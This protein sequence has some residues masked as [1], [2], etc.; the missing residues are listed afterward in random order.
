[1]RAGQERAHRSAG[2]TGLS[3]RHRLV[4]ATA[5]SSVGDGLV[6]VALPLL[7]L[8]S[9]TSALLVSGLLVAARLPWLVVGLPG[10]ALVDRVDRRRLVGVVDVGRAAVVAAVAAGALVTVLP[11]EVLYGAAFLVGAGET[12]VSTAVRA[13]V[14]LVGAEHDVVETNGRVNAA[15]TAG[16]RF[17]GPGLGGLVFAV[18]AS[19]PFAGDAAS[20][21]VSATILGTALPRGQQVADRPSTAL[22]ADIATGLRWFAGNPALRVLA[23]LVTSFAFCQ[24]MVMAVLVLYATEDLH[25][26]A[27][28]YGLLLAVASVGDIG[29]SLLAR[30]IHHRLGAYATVVVAGALAAAGYLFLSSTATAY[31]AAVALALEAAAT[32]LGNVATLSVR[33][34]VIPGD[35]F[36]L[37]NNAFRM[38]V[39]GCIPLGALAGGALATVIGF[40]QTFLVAGLVQLAVLGALARPLRRVGAE[41][42][43]SR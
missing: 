11:I 3:L 31:L 18:A 1:M 37:V 33:H 24:A 32:S 14:P 20:Y 38:P 6:L 19:L 42:P 22:R 12:L 21:L 16:S 39:T 29:A 10:G 8:R 34:R 2:A 9:T 5:V 4:T 35:R 25:L 27:T 23:G 7:A 13:S 26:G 15:R 43:A 28:G 40:H 17:A 41:P 36:G 30:R